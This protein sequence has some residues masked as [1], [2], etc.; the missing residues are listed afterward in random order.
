MHRLRDERGAHT[1]AP[2]IGLDEDTFQFCLVW[3]DHDHGETGRSLDTFRNDD[4]S[5][6]NPLRRQLDCLRIGVQLL[7]I[8]GE[9]AR[10]AMLKLFQV[11]PFVWPCR[12]RPD[13]KLS[14][15]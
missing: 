6:L 12:P 15:P 10:G 11:Q 5:P 4:L 8:F 7:A 3:A 1:P 9:R 2:Q 13:R 14:E